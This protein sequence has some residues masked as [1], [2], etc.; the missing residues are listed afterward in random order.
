MPTIGGSSGAQDTNVVS[1]PII[2]NIAIA[3]A[4]IEQSHSLPNNS[5]RFTIK[6]RGTGLIKLAYIAATSGSTYFSIEPGTTYDESEIRKETLTFYFQSPT[7]GDILE[8]ISW[9]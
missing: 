4:N 7:P 8:I 6:N 1:T 3:A 2:E 9:S 5:K